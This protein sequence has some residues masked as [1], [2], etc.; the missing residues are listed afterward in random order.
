MKHLMVLDEVKSG[1]NKLDSF[2]S[3]KKKTKGRTGYNS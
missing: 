2:R 3:L 1:K